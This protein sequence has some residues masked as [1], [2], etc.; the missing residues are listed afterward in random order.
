[1]TASVKS[2]TKDGVLKRVDGYTA[3]LDDIKEEEGFNLRTWMDPKELEEHLDSLFQAIMR[4]DELPP[5]EATIMPDGT[6]VL[7]DG[8]CRRIAYLRARAAGKVIGRINII[9]FKGDM[10]ARKL[11]IFQTQDGLKLSPLAMAMGYRDLRGLG[12]SLNEIATR[13]GKTPQ[14]VG[15]L[16]L[17]ADAPHAV[18]AQVQDGTISGALAIKL[19]QQHGEK[20]EGVVYEEVQKALRGG[21]KKVTAGTIKPAKLPAKVY[22]STAKEIEAFG[23]ELSASV[24]QELAGHEAAQAA[25]MDIGNQY[26]KLPASLVLSLALE[27]NNLAAARHEMEAKQRQKAEKAAQKDIDDGAAA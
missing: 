3:E 7:T 23:K 19:I 1:M 12:L 26:I 17:L 25:G 8:H 2:L 21:A 11:R 5:L 16:L 9:P 27:A 6:I 13:A 10:V 18:R 4:D 24:R 20:V 22:E 14:H 15:Q